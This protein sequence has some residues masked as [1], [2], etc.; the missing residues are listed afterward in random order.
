[1]GKAMSEK[2]RCK[3][4][5]RQI[6][7]ESVFCPYCGNRLIKQQ[8]ERKDESTFTGKISAGVQ[9]SL[10]AIRKQVNIFLQKAEKKVQDS[11]SISFVNKEKILNVLHQIQQ[12]D[13]KSTNKENAS[14]LTS[15]AKKVEEAISGNKCIVCLQEFDL[16]DKENL[17]VL[18]CPN[19]S[20]AGHPKH[21]QDW[22]KEKETCPMC[23]SELQ[24]DSLIKGILEIKNE[25]LVFSST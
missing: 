4:C 7:T 9:K 6:P 16:F 10:Q 17:D 13:S 14:E 25:E 23:R 11:D 1:M 15:W 24:K 3:F 2:K 20:Y 5:S 22:L 12:K 21:F 8:K 18:L 19:C